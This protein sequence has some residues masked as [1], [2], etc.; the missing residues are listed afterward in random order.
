MANKKLDFKG[1]SNKELLLIYNRVDIYFDNLNK[2]LEKSELHKNITT[3][4]GPK[5]EIIELS[6]NDIKTIMDSDYYNT[7][8]SIVDKLGPIVSLINGEEPEL[9]KKLNI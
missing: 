4:N 8:R 1:L 3:S 9:K 2:N 6:S 5:I 7:L